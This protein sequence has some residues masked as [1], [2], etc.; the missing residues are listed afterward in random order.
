MAEARIPLAD[1]NKSHAYEDVS[2]LK[3]LEDIFNDSSYDTVKSD[4]FVLN[5]SNKSKIEKMAEKIKIKMTNENIDKLN[6]LIKKTYANINHENIELVLKTDLRQRILS[7]DGELYLRTSGAK[8]KQ[9]K[10]GNHTYKAIKITSSKEKYLKKLNTLQS[11]EMSV[12]DNYFQ[13]LINENKTNE[14]SFTLHDDQGNTAGTTVRVTLRGSYNLRV[15]FCIRFALT[16]AFAR[17][18]V[19]VT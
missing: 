2:T 7:K 3:E 6:N 9:V 17:Y 12:K 15:T 10:F 19:T 5:I 13:L 11:E 4:N 16:L 14:T 18:N 1:L 8:V